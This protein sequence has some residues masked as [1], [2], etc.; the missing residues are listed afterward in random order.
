M[1]LTFTIPTLLQNLNL[2]TLQPR[3]QTHNFH[4]HINLKVSDIFSEA[5]SIK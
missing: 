5:T 3:F 1:I 4:F 2:I